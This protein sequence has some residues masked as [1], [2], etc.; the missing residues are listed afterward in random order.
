MPVRCLVRSGSYFDSVVLMRI[1]AEIGGR[2][3]VRTAS[4]VMATA[5]NKDV[6]ESAGLLEGEART[7]ARTTSWSPSTRAEDAADDA[8]APPRR[9]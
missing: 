1:A 6:L 5:S 8:L 7:R 2:A 4:L 9:R 3:G